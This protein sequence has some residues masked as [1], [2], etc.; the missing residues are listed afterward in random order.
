MIEFDPLVPLWAAA[1]LV[2]LFAAGVALALWRAPRLAPM[3]ALIALAALV[4]LFN[5]VRTI[6][7]RAPQRDI[8]IA[9][10]DRS[11]SMAVDD[12]GRAAAAALDALRR[13]SPD[14][15]WRVVPVTPRPG[16]PTRLLPALDRALQ[17][18]PA[19][20]LAGAVALT[21]GIV[22]DSGPSP[23]PPDKPLHLLLAGDPDLRDR[24]LIVTRVPPYS[25]VGRPAAISIRIDDGPA[26]AAPAR[27]DWQVDG[28]PQP[29]R[30]VTPGEVVTLPVRIERRGPIEIALSVS[31]LD[32]ERSLV[33]NRA[34]VR[35]NGVRDRLRVLLVSGVPYPGGRV[36]RDVLKSDPNIDLVHFTIL[37]LPTSFDPTP[38]DQLA[39]IPFPTD[40]L[41]ERQLPR[42][43]L[44][45]F[46][47]F[48]LT[49]LLAPEYF[50][51]IV[52]YVR[53]GGG[54]FV[55]AGDE[56][57]GPGSLAATTLGEILPALPAGPPRSARFTP[58]LTDDG[59]R[60]PVTAVLQP[61]WGAWGEQAT[62][63]QRRGQLLMT[64]ANG[65]PLLLLDRID[66][67]RIGLLGSTDVWWWARAVEGAGPRD[68]LLRRVAHW[69][70]QEPD[71]A[72]D[73]LDVRADDRILRIAANGLPPPPT[74]V[75]AGPDGDARP[76]ALVDG[77]ASVPARRDGLWRV[78]AGG[79][80]R[81]VLVGDAV[82]L[83]EVRPRAAPLDGLAAR[84]QWLG[85]GVPAIRRIRPGDPQT[86]AGWIGLVENRSGQLVGVR[87]APLLP[88]WAALALLIGLLAAA[89]WRERR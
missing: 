73:R 69:L 86:G 17:S 79:Q 56:F 67:G 76:I 49:E 75:V 87:T 74:A 63:R 46:D 15:D 52:T 78:D 7:E 51:R 26:A 4:V 10:V 65:A 84:A 44:V 53:N 41:F 35:L 11:A 16:E 13:A 8:A 33:N 38:G 30:D 82:E 23:M 28:V 77:R 9:L 71:L 6:E 32:G 45:V 59:Q 80:R 72:E 70:M 31:P 14:L 48:G 22:A 43:D 2:L 20:R 83:A 34:L 24:R 68:E 54:L 88:P 18:V 19:D 25:V 66:K 21:D 58:A 5:P 85:D 57:A 1:P 47:R 60:H 40:E 39:L 29:P 89:W 64:G 27:L 12:R 55:V 81:F 50:D 62:L 37:R 3:R 36:W 42:F 61:P